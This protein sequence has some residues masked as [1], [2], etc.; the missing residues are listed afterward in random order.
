MYFFFKVLIAYKAILTALSLS[1]KQLLLSGGVSRLAYPKSGLVFLLLK[2]LAYRYK[3]FI[4][5]EINHIKAIRKRA[6]YIIS[7]DERKI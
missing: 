3:G 1:Y 2:R 5:A 6:N 4:Q 7:F